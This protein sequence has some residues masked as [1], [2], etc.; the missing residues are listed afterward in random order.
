MI[1]LPS[2]LALALAGSMAAPVQAAPLFFQPHR[3]VSGALHL[4]LAATRGG[5][6]RT[7]QLPTQTLRNIRRK[8]LSRRRV[9]HAQLRLLADTGDG[10]AALLFAKRIEAMKDPKLGADAVHYYSRAAYSGRKSALPALVRLLRTANV[11][12]DGNKLRQAEAALHAHAAKGSE[13]ATASLAK[14]YRTG[15]PFGLK[16]E[17]AERLMRRSAEA[18]DEQAA[19]DLAVALM[20][21][22]P[23][24]D[25]TRRDMLKYLELAKGSEKPGLQAMAETLAK[26][27]AIALNQPVAP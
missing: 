26:T 19:F 8:M 12:L 25:E 7:D 4:H 22:Q 3:A 14:F 16:P 10:L 18:G 21:K 20:Q 2:I 6:T 23:Q 13:L 11:A 27:A 24:T 9:S 5:I 17:E 15:S 1:R